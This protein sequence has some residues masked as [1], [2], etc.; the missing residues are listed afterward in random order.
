MPAKKRGNAKNTSFNVEFVNFKLNPAEKKDFETWHSEKGNAMLKA[1]HETLEGD[2]KL[3]LSYDAN[4]EC[5]IAAMTGRDESLN[6]NRCIT[7]R[8]TDWQKA[9]FSLAY[10]NA[11]IFKYGVWDFESDTDM[12]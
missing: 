2:Y 1:L 10:I 6:P 4:N 3:S 9:L 7:M 8:S 12:V 5:F 11:V